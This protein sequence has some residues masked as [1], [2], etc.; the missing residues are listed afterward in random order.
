MRAYLPLLLLLLLL[1]LPS[2][3]RTAP[4]CAVCTTACSRAISLLPTITRPLVFHHVEVAAPGDVVGVQGARFGIAGSVLVGTVDSTGVVRG[5]TCAT[6][7][8]RQDDYLSFVVPQLFTLGLY[9]FW[10]RTGDQVGGPYYVNKATVWWGEYPEI[11]P[12]SVFRLFGINLKLASGTPTVTFTSGSSVLSGTVGSGDG[13]A[14]S[15]TAPAGLVAGQSYTV[16]YSNGFGGSIGAYTLSSVLPVIA[17]AADTLSL[18]VPWSASFA[19][20]ASNVYNVKT[21]VRL[22][23]FAVGDGVACDEAALQGAIDKA[24]TDGGGV[25][26]LPSG[27]YRLCTYPNIL[28][29]D[30]ALALKSNVVV[31]GAG[32]ALTTLL[33][34]PTGAPPHTQYVTIQVFSSTVNTAGVLGLTV[35]FNQAQ[36]NVGMLFGTAT[37]ISKM[38]VK[39]IIVN[40]NTYGNNAL[41]MSRGNRFLVDG[42][43]FTGTKLAGQVLLWGVAGS[44][45]GAQ[46]LSVRNNTIQLTKGIVGPSSNAVIENNDSY[47]DSDYQAAQELIEGNVGE[48]GRLFD[49][50]N[51]GHSVAILAN[52]VRLQGSILPNHLN[53]GEYIL[54][55]GLGANNNSGTVTSAATTT[56]SD[57]SKTFTVNALVGY[58]VYIA[59]GVGWGQVRTVISNTATEIT[60]SSAW[61]LTPSAGVTYGVYLPQQQFLVGHNTFSD[62][63]NYFMFYEG[64]NTSVIYDNT[65]TNANGPVIIGDLRAN[66]NRLVP[67]YDMMMIDNT[68]TRTLTTV[69]V[70]GDLPLRSHFMALLSN[71]TG[72]AAPPNV[73]TNIL[74]RGN[75]AEAAAH[76]NNIDFSG[77]FR[78]AREGFNSYVYQT[79]QTL[80]GPYTSGIAGIVYDK[81]TG[82]TLDTG[83]SIGA[84]SSGVVVYVPTSMDVTNLIGGEAGTALIAD[85]DLRTFA[86]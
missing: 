86:Q 41:N 17:S 47:Y 1:I 54:F 9:A 39:N 84:G 18:G 64:G 22:P 53:D 2:D 59:D 77:L 32:Q 14:V 65:F 20:F 61:D 35:Q 21:D 50:L 34:D 6:V 68:A 31:Q 51:G 15:V 78:H 5:I 75:A 13:Y 33:G 63:Y 69:E 67:A 82:I 72:V 46:W 11:Q 45:V 30:V 8:K 83:Y 74:M 56:L 73:V 79:A 57:S 66:I 29:Y 10:I 36:P 80:G 70:S 28:T 71:T 24:N 27:T 55:Q 40:G 44:T 49:N 48:Q 62:K 26:Y 60:V 38:F 76:P 4:Q 12:S 43:T 81:N 19:A 85:V 58:D 25:V 52:T 7:L 23:A 42:C 3:G 37:T 16:T